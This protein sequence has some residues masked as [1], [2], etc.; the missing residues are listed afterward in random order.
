MSRSTLKAEA[1]KNQSGNLMSACEIDSAYIHMQYQLIRRSASTRHYY[2][3]Y[4][5]YY[6]Y[7]YYH[8]KFMRLATLNVNM[9]P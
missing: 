2:Y 8:N 7:Y 1:S 4:Y 3:Y 9:S 5:Y 6:H